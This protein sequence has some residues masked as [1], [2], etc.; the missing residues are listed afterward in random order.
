MQQGY[1]LSNSKVSSLEQFKGFVLSNK[2]DNKQ[3]LL[4]IDSFSSER[5]E[6]I[7]GGF[8]AIAKSV[9]AMELEP[10]EEPKELPSGEE[11][12]EEATDE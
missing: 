7:I 5:H 4:Q 9:K 6:H 3:T 12:N 8:H 2:L 1:P 10:P 11:A